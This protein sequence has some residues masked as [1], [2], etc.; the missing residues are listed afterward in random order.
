MDFEEQG[1]TNIY[2]DVGGKALNVGRASIGDV[3]NTRRSAGQTVFCFDRVSW[4]CAG[5]EGRNYGT[6]INDQE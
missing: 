5:T 6:N 1:L 4:R 2:T 3:P